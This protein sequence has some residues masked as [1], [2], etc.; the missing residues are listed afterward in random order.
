MLTFY[1]K[2]GIRIEIR[3]REDGHKEPHVHVVYA[4]ENMSVSIDTAETLAG[5]IKVILKITRL[6]ER[7]LAG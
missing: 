7:L 2:D 1:Y 5:D 4:G 3:L 6:G